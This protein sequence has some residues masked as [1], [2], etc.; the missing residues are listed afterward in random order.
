ME[1]DTAFVRTDGRVHLHTE[2]TVDLH[3]ALV[4]HPRHAEHDHALG[5]H[6]ALHHF[7]LAQVRVRHYHRCYRVHYFFDCLVKLFLT[8]VLSDEVRH[9]SVHIHLCLFVHH[10][11][12]L[13]VY[14]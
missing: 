11:M 6:H 13:V 1:T 5:L 4:I 2:T 12:L 14:Q 10:T 8:G 3:L 7:L 9:K